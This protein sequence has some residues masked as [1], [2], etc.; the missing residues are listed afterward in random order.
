M[1]KNQ[2]LLNDLLGKVE[3]Q[4]NAARGVGRGQIEQSVAEGEIAAHDVVPA[5]QYVCASGT[6]S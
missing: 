6:A 5:G 1:S 3:C 2:G 4:F